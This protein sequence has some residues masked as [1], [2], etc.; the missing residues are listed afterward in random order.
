MNISQKLQDVPHTQT[1]AYPLRKGEI[2]PDLIKR[3]RRNRKSDAIRSLAQENFLLAQQFVS[4]FFILEGQQSKQEIPSMP[5]VYRLTL[6]LILKEIDTLCKLGVKTIDLFPF[7]PHDKRDLIGSEALRHNN[8]MQR[9]VRMIKQAF[10]EVCVMVDIAL[11]PFTS[12][13][14][15]GIVTSDGKIDNDATLAA[16]SEMSLRA[17][18]A[19]ADIVAPSDMMDGRI[20]KIRKTLDS[21]GFTEIGILAYTAKYASSFYGPFRDALESAPKFGDKK[22][23]QMNPANQ[24]EALLEAILDEKEGADLLLVK[25]ALPYLDI[26]TKLRDLTYLPIG[27]YQVSGEYAMIKAAGANQW[28]DAEKVMYESLLSIRRAGADFIFTYAA[29]EM[30]EYIRYKL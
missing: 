18:E 14:H 24:R 15:D 19:G 16:L 30:A 25:P 26:I 13:G 12:H 6:D 29:K 21:Q 2:D 9:S 3:P 23:Y 17:A 8:L 1:N 4:P 28:I 7:I 27:A 10:P 11:D 22:T 5:G 20:G